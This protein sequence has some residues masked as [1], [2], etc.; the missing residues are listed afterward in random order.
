[1]KNIKGLRYIGKGYNKQVYHKNSCR[2][3]TCKQ[4]IRKDIIPKIVLWSFIVVWCLLV[5]VALL[6]F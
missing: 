6:A 4:I 3:L 1:M 2:C 5:V